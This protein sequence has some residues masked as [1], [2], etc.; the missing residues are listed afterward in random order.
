MDHRISDNDSINTEIQS[1]RG[2]AAAAAAVTGFA[3]E[4]M[5]IMTQ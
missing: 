2:R 4:M 1:E 5:I 3:A